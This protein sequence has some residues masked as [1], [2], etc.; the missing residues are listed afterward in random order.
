MQPKR[1]SVYELYFD[2]GTKYIGKDSKQRMQQAIK[3][4]TSNK[5]RN[6]VSKK[7]TL[8]PND[9]TAFIMEHIK[10]VESRFDQVGC[11]LLNSINSPGKKLIMLL[12]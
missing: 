1:K 4:W 3:K 9:T 5:S 7:F 12:L 10:M 8:F 11:T 6:L 2:D